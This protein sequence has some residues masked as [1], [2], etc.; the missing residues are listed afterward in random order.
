MK[1]TEKQKEAALL[2]RSDSTDILFYGGSRSGKT[3][4]LCEKLF[5][6]A[7]KYPRT[8]YLIARHR[9]T[10]AK[11]SIWLDTLQKT[12]DGRRHICKVNE[13]DHFIKLINGSEI[14]VD[15]LDDAE[16]AER[17]LGREYNVIYVNEISKG[18]SY[19]TITLLKTRLALKT[20]GLLNR[21]LYDCNPPSIYH[22]AY[23]L[24]VQKV[25]PESGT[26][27]RNPDSYASILMNPIDN[28]EHLP[29]AYLQTLE[30]LPEYARRRF[31]LGEF[32]KPEGAIF[33]DITIVDEIPSIVKEKARQA[34][35]LD[36]G[37]SVDPT[38]IVNVYDTGDELWLDEIIYSTG[39]S[40]ERIADE[41]KSCKID[42]SA[43]IIADCAEPKSIDD[44]IRYGYKGTLPCEK[45]ADSIRYGI[46]VMLRKK[47][48]ITRHSTNLLEE[49][50]N[51]VW[52]QDK[53]G[54]KMNEPEGGND[55][56]ID[57]V[58]YVAMYFAKKKG[59]YAR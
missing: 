57:A 5:Y 9:W 26:P 43:R 35:G 51:Y 56:G 21:M 31:L 34:Y 11:A 18:V 19:P 25:N 23:K 24:F 10:E 46:D 16:R 41:M 37:Y 33:E 27:L 44:L 20:E 3:A 28:K 2:F 53:S 29:D 8:R 58:R 49:F 1:L 59:W 13:Q 47:I 36:F 50:Q 30:E 42:Y 15:G 12:M 17:I 55:H 40:N 54:M 32:T 22:W 48:H 38:A 52:R 39:L 45:G 4:L 6:W 7:A 14:W